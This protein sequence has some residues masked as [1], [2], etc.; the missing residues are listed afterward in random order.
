MQSPPCSR[1]WARPCP[2]TWLCPSPAV[3]HLH[4][5]CSS[6]DLL[7]RAPR[8]M[9]P[10]QN[11]RVP[12]G[13]QYKTT[14][15][16]PLSVRASPDPQHSPD[17]GLQPGLGPLHRVPRGS[18]G[19][20]RS[21]RCPWSPRCPL[22]V[23]SHVAGPGRAPRSA[24][25]PPRAPIGPTPSVPRSHWPGAPRPAL[26]LAP[27]PSTNKGRCPAGGPARRSHWRGEGAWLPSQATPREQRRVS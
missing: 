16:P 22:A 1:C 12:P 5:G 2:Y 13:I 7:P 24:P 3:S 11:G 21:P 23:P 27:E 9:P 4:R 14:P 19:A 26:P 15:L 25:R 8:T 10:P 6:R 18:T 17:R 20:G